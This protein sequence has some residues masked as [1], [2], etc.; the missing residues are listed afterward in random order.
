MGTGTVSTGAPAPV[1]R[2]CPHRRP[3]IP[4]VG[5][6]LPAALD[7]GAGGCGQAGLA[8]LW[9]GLDP[10]PAGRL[11]AA[12]RH[13]AVGAVPRQRPR[14][15]PGLHAPAIRAGQALLRRARR[16]GAGRRPRGRVVAG[17]PGTSAFA[18]FRGN[19][20]RAG[21]LGDPPVL[22]CLRRGRGRGHR[23]L[24]RTGPGRWTC[25]IS[26]SGKAASRTARCSRWS[27]PRWSAPTPRCSPPSTTT[28]A[29]EWRT[30]G[31]GAWRAGPGPASSRGLGSP[32]RLLLRGLRTPGQR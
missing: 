6:L 14:R 20:R 22:L 5:G 18:R 23:R 13:P 28:N 4:D 11:A 8:G 3:G 16:P 10:D 21:R 1:V 30:A 7:Q 12:A 15:G 27:T 26:G 17:A 9:H 31:P 2:S 25:P 32:P 24:R 29:D 19:Q